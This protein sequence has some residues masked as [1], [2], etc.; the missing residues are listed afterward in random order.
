VSVKVVL[1]LLLVTALTAGCTGQSDPPTEATPPAGPTESAVSIGIDHPSLDGLDADVAERITLARRNAETEDSAASYGQLGMVYQVHDFP[2]AARASYLRAVEMDSAAAD[3]HYYL[4]LLARRAGEHD[5]ARQH[6]DRVLEQEPA[7]LPSIVW[8]AEMSLTDNE[9]DN[10]ESGFRR[11]LELQSDSAAALFGLGRVALARE[12]NELAIGYLLDGLALAPDANAI[13]YPLALAYR[14]QGDVERA[15]EH[16]E[17]RGDVVPQPPDPRRGALQQLTEG[18]RVHGLRGTLLF[19]EGR[20]EDA[21]AEFEAAVEVTPEDPLPHNNLGRTLIETGDIEGARKAFE[22]AIEISP[23][24]PIANYNLGTL[25]AQLGD[26]NAA[27][28]HHRIVVSER[29]EM[30]DAHF[31]L[32]NA[33]R[34][35]G[36]HAAAVPHYRV[37]I[38]GDP[39][40][41][42][43]RLAEAYTLIRLQRDAEARG[44]LEEAYEAIPDNLEICNAL[45]RVLA[46]ASDP[47]V[48]DPRQAMALAQK[49]LVEQL[50]V[51]YATTLAM[52]A[53]SIGRFQEAAALQQ[54]VITQVRAGGLD[55]LLPEL[56]ANLQRYRSGQPATAP[57]SMDHPL[58]SPS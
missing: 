44:R 3:W 46:G 38:E 31:N 12:D 15:N 1:G 24:D 47:A 27:I 52:V 8:N 41:A 18:T 23:R 13:H 49:L 30:F 45:A 7:D 48:R 42:A 56:E 32:A 16:L 51:E 14:G 17:A 2:L 57:W 25:L 55:G 50:H 5:E 19:K 43:A 36:Q 58:L 29:P 54:Q 37:V 33:L 9:Y 53:A 28:E 39:G 21:K 22:K 11:V 20:V 10:A 35:T 26:D 34:R 6:F 4:G 40:R